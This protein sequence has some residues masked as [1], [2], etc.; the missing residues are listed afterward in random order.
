MEK[1]ENIFQMKTAG[2]MKS[3]IAGWNVSSLAVSLN[4]IRG[5]SYPSRELNIKSH[6]C[7]LWNVPF[8]NIKFLN[9]ITTKYA[10]IFTKQGNLITN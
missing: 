5:W 2:E 9:K 10:L 4:L 3:T 8:T 7:D 1:I 6:L